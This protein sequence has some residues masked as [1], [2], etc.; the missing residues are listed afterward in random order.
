MSVDLVPEVLTAVVWIEM[1]WMEVG[2]VVEV[3]GREEVVGGDWCEIE[4]VS[5]GVG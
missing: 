5:G 4:P 2:Q 3:G 1:E